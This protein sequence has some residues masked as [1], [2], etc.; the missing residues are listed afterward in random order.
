MKKDF[1][2]TSAFRLITYLIFPI[3]L[4]VTTAEVALRV[5]GYKPWQIENVDVAVEPKGNF[6]TKDSELGYKHLPGKFKVT[7]NGNYSFNATHLNNSLRITHPLNT[8]N[9]SSTK[10]EIWI[11]GCSFTYGW[12]LNDNET[13]A[14]LLQAKLPQYEIVN[15]GVNGYGTL[16]SFIQFKEALKQGN[17]PK[18]AVIAYAGFHDRRNTLL[19]ARRKQMAAWNKLGI[20]LQPDARLDGKDNF[21]YTMTKLEYDEWPLMRVSAL[22]NF[23]EVNYNQFEEGLYKSHD[24]SKAIIEEF[25]RLAEA[26]GVKL[27]V[28]GINAGSAKML[29]E[30]SQEGIATVDISVNL[31]IPANNNLPHD[32]HPSAVAN[33]QYADKLENFLQGTVLK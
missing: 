10:P 20:L 30:L 28:A 13:Y 4:S 32:L 31:K 22:V 27:V 16:H 11:L 15:F 24:V 2:K 14:W 19:R 23:L 33:R 7:L 6:F 8:Y 17:K 26:N 9:Q 5:A 18:I 25:N 3:L 21:T 29:E 12:S 1:L